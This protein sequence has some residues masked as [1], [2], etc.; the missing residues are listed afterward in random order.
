M[1]DE[2]FFAGESNKNALEYKLNELMVFTITPRHGDE[3]LDIPEF[4]NYKWIIEGDDGRKESGSAPVNGKAP[5]VLT[6]SLS[7]PGFVRVK[8]EA[9]DGN[10][11]PLSNVT[12]FLG[13]A[14]AEV[15]KIECDTKM[16][17]DFDDFW[18]NIVK[19]L[20][21]HGVVLEEKIPYSAEEEGFSVYKIKLKMPFGK[22]VW[23]LLSIPNGGENLPAKVIYCGYGVYSIEPVLEKEYITL[24]T[25]VHGLE[26]GLSEEYYKELG[27]EPDGELYYYGFDSIENSNPDNVYFKSVIARDLMAAKFIKTLPQ[28]N[29]KELISQGGSQGAFRATSVAAHDKDITEL[30]ITVPWFCNLGGY[31]NGR[32]RGW[33][34][35]YVEG[36]CYFDTANQMTRVECPVNV[37]AKLGDYTCPPS[38]VMAAYNNCKNKKKITFYQNGTH[39][40]DCPVEIKYEIESE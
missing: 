40:Y 31:K 32:M 23:S 13:G 17:D 19:E 11:N 15:E 7:R 28:W 18:E 20:D 34:P 36:V 25:D 9:C 3:F 1:A 33:S 39:A 14:G 26:P 37:S 4:K 6:A 35:D 16:P 29:K 38:S 2:Y 21:S 22:P 24:V 30:N 10:L 5:L 8:V 27:R 12:C